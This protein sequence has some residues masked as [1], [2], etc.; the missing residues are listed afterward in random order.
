MRRIVI[1][2]NIRMMIGYLFR[3]KILSLCNI[4]KI[5]REHEV[6]AS[7]INFSYDELVG[8]NG[9]MAIRYST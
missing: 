2:I 8:N 5:R 3:P 9:N 6:I 1:N 4:E 7:G